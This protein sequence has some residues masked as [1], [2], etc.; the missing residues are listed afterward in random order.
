MQEEESLVRRAQAGEASAFASI[1]ERYFDRVYRYILLRVGSRMD[2][3]DLTEQVFLKALEKMGSFRWRGVPFSA[4]L[5]RIAHNQMVDHLRRRGRD[6]P[7]LGDEEPAAADDPQAALE[8]K[9]S[10]EELSAA[11]GRLTELQRQ[12]VA[13]RF[14]AGL[15]VAETA[16]AV[17]RSEGAVKALQHSALASLRRHM[18]VTGD[19]H[20]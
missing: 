20:D 5:F 4:W 6:M 9:L 12:V 14:A 19:K 16:R 13:L 3:E 7:L 10:M 1:Y 8:R 2:A 17:E 15:S 11:V 18:G